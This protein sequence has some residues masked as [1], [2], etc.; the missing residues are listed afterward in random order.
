V[1]V[2]RRAVVV[3]LTEDDAAVLSRQLVEAI[4]LAYVAR[5]R[6]P[7]H[8]LLTL[9]TAVSQ[10]ARSFAEVRTEPQ[11]GT[12]RELAPVRGGPVPSSSLEPV[13]LSAEEAARVG[14]VTV[15]QMRKFLRRG[16]LKGER[17]G[18]RGSW[19]VGTNELGAW[20][21]RRRKERQ[22]AA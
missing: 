10:A 5:G 9:S 16:D 22:K 12:P 8:Q 7:P 13:W 6:P 4:R 3:T 15:Q 2:V 14:K 19:L 21:E 1:E 18:H 11:V 17:S 20:L